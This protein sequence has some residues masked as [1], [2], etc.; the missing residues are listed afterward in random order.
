[1]S[2][3]IITATIAALVAMASAG[4]SLYGQAQITQ[5]GDRLAKQRE[6]E[7]R[8]AQ[9][10]ALMAQYRDPLLRSAIDLQSRLF[11]I[12]EMRFLQRFYHQS[13]AERD[14][15]VYNT[16]Y[17]IADYFG[18]AEILRREVQF[19]DI[20][21]LAENRQ[22]SELFIAV[23]KAFGLSKIEPTLR[24]FH[25]EQ[26]AI[27]E[28]M[29]VPRKSGQ[30]TGYDCIGYATFVKKMSDPD[31]FYWFER[32]KTDLEGMVE[33]PSVGRERMALIQGRLIDLI[34]FLDPHCVRIS[35]TYRTRIQP[36][37]ESSKKL[38][39]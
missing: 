4:L 9:T 10:A 15:T 28:I 38:N 22:L 8:E 11:N 26:R 3:E 21:G 31:F 18:W 30:V 29:M 39:Q 1:M 20:G 16:L 2:P 12:H 36:A 25:G 19:L 35:P 32:L 17:V 5:M 13:A 24:L 6:A 33:D 27:G 14:Y 23:S 7:S 34:D 37:K